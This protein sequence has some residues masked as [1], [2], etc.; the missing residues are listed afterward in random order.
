MTLA[1]A[2]S[3]ERWQTSQLTQEES[4]DAEKSLLLSYHS[5]SVSRPRD[6]ICASLHCQVTGMISGL[7]GDN[8]DNHLHHPLDS[9]LHRLLTSPD[10]P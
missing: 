1:V 9:L 5:K 3:A 10:R 2:L 8:I 6:L 7:I 4:N